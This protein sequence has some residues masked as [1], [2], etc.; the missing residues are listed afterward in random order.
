MV[1]YRPA[2]QNRLRISQS[3]LE[4]GFLEINIPSAA[5]KAAIA[6]TKNKMGAVMGVGYKKS[7]STPMSRTHVYLASQISYRVRHRQE[8][9]Q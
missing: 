1:K 2:T 9:I 3:A 6:N 8:K 4:T 7:G 5:A